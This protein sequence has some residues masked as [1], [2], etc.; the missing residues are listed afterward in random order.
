MVT[1]DVSDCV[2]TANFQ[3][4]FRF[5]SNNVAEFFGWNIDDIQVSDES[6]WVP[7]F[8]PAHNVLILTG[9]IGIVWMFTLRNKRENRK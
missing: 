4:Q 1:I 7:E 8:I 2:G 9:I 5:F 6:S 3:F